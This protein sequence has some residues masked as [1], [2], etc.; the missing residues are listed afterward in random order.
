M[1]DDE[2]EKYVFFVELIFYK[3]LQAKN[4][5]YATLVCA[6]NPSENVCPSKWDLS[7]VSEKKNYKNMLKPL[8]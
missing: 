7:Q 1:S 5:I 4:I 2:Q 8:T 6:L 3:C